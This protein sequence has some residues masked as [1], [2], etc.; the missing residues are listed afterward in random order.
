MP[1]RIDHFNRFSPKVDTS[2][3]FYNDLGFRVT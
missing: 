3:A 1:L 2:V